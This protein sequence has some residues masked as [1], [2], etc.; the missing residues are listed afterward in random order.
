MPQYA[1]TH[2]FAREVITARTEALTAELYDTIADYHTYT[3]HGHNANIV[4][5]FRSPRWDGITVCNV[6]RQSSS[7]HTPL[8][9]P[10]LV[11]ADQ[12]NNRRVPALC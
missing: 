8:T 6:P 3:F 9:V 5:C 2:V 11:W 1:R 10:Y 7:F 12:R 4:A